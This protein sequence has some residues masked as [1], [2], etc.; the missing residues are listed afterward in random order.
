MT[1]REVVELQAQRQ[2]RPTILLPSPIAEW[3]PAEILDQMKAGST[4]AKARAAFHNAVA[5]QEQALEQRRPPSPL[6][7]RRMEFQA[8]VEIAKALG[9][10]VVYETE[11]KTK[12]KPVIIGRKTDDYTS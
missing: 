10:E 6:E 12:T 1:D 4:L 7:L 5:S 11:T 8:V 9:L 2:A 3:T